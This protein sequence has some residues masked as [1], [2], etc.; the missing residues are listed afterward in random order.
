MYTGSGSLVLILDW[1]LGLL[2]RILSWDLGHV[3]WIWVTCT[4]IW[5]TCIDPRLGSGSFVQDFIL[6]YRPC[7]LDLGHLYILDVFH[8]GVFPKYIL[9][10]I[11]ESRSHRDLTVQTLL[12]PPPTNK[13]RCTQIWW[14]CPQLARSRDQVT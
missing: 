11:L 6:G 3:Y 8:L 5:V 13:P 10:L 9:D 4:G 1:D 7:I 14:M 2:Y 12:P